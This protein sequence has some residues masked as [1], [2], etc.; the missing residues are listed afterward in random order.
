MYENLP[1]PSIL[2]QPNIPIPLHGVNPRSVLGKGWWDRVRQS[3]YVMYSYRC[4]ACDVHKSRALFHTWL[5]AHEV[6]DY[7]WEKHLL[8]FKEIVALCHACH[9]FIHSGRLR[10][11]Y[12]NDEISLAKYQVIL[13]HG[14]RVLGQAGLRPFNAYPVSFV[15]EYESAHF[16]DWSLWRMDINGK[17]YP[18]KFRD[19]REW[20]K[21]YGG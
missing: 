5:E 4:W 18:P 12:E 19:R 11:M 3:A 8:V 1:D 7:R 16:A 20:E 6:Y 13:A 14:K 9:N 10:A 21:E 17:L 15:A 2:V